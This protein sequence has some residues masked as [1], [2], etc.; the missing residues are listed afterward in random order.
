M[1]SHSPNPNSFD[2]PDWHMPVHLNEI[3]SR[4]LRAARMT[5]HPQIMAPMSE[6]RDHKNLVS[7]L[8]T[9]KMGDLQILQPLP[10]TIINSQI[11]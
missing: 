1:D 9:K 3:H 10:L 5:L 6:T 2:P 8:T 7:D 4:N 11:Q